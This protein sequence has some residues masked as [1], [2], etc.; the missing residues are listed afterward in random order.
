MKERDARMFNI[1]QF[2]SKRDFG[3]ICKKRT[4]KV[5]RERE[6]ERERVMRGG[7]KFKA[8]HSGDEYKSS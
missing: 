8:H 2:Q 5:A 3:I 7:D 1:Q 6:R 4:E